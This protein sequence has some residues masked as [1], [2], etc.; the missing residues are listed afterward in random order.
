[1]NAGRQSLSSFQQV[2]WSILHVNRLNFPSYKQLFIGAQSGARLNVHIPTYMNFFIC[3]FEQVVKASCN[4][5]DVD[6]LTGS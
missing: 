3:L 6:L 5:A 2:S 4:L 1:M